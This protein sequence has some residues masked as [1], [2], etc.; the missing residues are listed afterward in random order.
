MPQ[1][2]IRRQREEVTVKKE[3]GLPSLRVSIQFWRMLS[4]RRVPS[5]TFG[6]VI[7]DEARGGNIGRF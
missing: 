7:E 5:Q 1:L 2:L 4:A 3:I 6:K